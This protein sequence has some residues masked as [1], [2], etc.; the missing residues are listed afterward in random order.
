MTEARPTPEFAHSPL[1]HP[2]DIV[3]WKPP[4]E[5]EWI[6]VFISQDAQA[7]QDKDNPSDTLNG[8][9]LYNGVKLLPDGSRPTSGTMYEYEISG[10]IRTVQPEE[11]AAIEADFLKGMQGENRPEEAEPFFILTP[12]HIEAIL[13]AST[14]DPQ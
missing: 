9:F 1:Y 10:K 12:E 5:L 4:Q 2:H 3:V 8:T 14:D 7:Y 11:A 6:A 13:K